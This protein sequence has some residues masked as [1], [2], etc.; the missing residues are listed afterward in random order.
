MAP[1]NPEPY[2]LTLNPPHLH[3]DGQGAR[4]LLAHHPL[5]PLPS[6]PVCTAQCT[7][8]YTMQYSQGMPHLHHD[9]HVARL[10]L[11]RHRSRH[12]LRQLNKEAQQVLRAV[13]AARHA[14]VGQGLSG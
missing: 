12:E 14:A 10:L 8:Q 2:P 5:P 4:L 3:H 6:T 13:E 11:A 1:L 7:H 9:G